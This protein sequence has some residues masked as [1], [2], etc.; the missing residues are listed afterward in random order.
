[1]NSLAKLAER[2]PWFRVGHWDASVTGLGQKIFITSISRYFIRQ[3]EF[4]Q[5]SYCS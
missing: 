5:P 2:D 4:E 3:K 1:M